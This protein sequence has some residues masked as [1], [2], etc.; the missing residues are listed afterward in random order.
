MAKFGSARISE[1]SHHF[2]EPHDGYNGRRQATKSRF[3]CRP[4]LSSLY[5]ETRR[6][7]AASCEL[8][9]SAR[10]SFT[11]LDFHRIFRRDDCYLGWIR[12]YEA[13]DKRRH[14]LGT[15]FDIWGARF[16]TPVQTG[17]GAH[18]ISYTMG[19]VSPRE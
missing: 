15:Y 5:R 3:P 4:R 9:D 18:Q 7:L 19:T 14:P 2:K 12:I 8:C 16:S 6:S 11:G 17:P 13:N 10:I 1:I